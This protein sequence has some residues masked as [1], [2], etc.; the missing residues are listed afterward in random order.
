MRSL[1]VVSAVLVTAQAIFETSHC[2]NC[3]I[4]WSTDLDFLVLVLKNLI[5]FC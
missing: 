5:G 4:N 2:V 3:V 1:F